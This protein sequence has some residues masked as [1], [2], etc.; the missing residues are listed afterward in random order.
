MIILF[1]ESTGIH[2]FVVFNS[3]LIHFFSPFNNICNVLIFMFC[4]S[5]DTSSQSLAGTGYQELD[6]CQITLVER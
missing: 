6:F 3:L 2:D 5:G 1:I 4:F